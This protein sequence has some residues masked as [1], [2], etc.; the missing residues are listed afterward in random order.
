MVGNELK[1]TD[2]ERQYVSSSD[3]Q[4]VGYD[5]NMGT[6]E[7]RFHSGGTYRYFGVPARVHSSLMGAASHGRYFHR[8]IKGVYRY[9]KV[10]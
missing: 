1:E 4:S 5:A 2:T 7:I 10:G 6:L 8:H 9:S 3:L